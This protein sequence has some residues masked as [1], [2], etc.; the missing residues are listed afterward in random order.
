[1]AEPRPSP[2]APGVVA[3]L[4]IGGMCGFCIGVAVLVG[5]LLDGVF[6]T[7]PLLVF[8]GLAIGIVGAA[9]GSYVI[10]RPYLANAPTGAS[11]LDD[12]P[13]GSSDVKE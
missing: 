1:M 9:T 12:A 8:V 7:T 10:I 3:L 13:I 11:A 4:Q 5:Y 6:G 2:P